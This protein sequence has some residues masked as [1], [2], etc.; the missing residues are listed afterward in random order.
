M[1]ENDT[2]C[3]L[4]TCEVRQLILLYVTAVCESI[5]H[6][7]TK[8]ILFRVTEVERWMPPSKD[9]MPPPTARPPHRPVKH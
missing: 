5:K 1:N 9:A 7:V 8:D 4:C 6:P 2:K 3:F